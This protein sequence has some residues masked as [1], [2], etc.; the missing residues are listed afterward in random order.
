MTIRAI[1]ADNF[2]SPVVEWI[3]IYCLRKKEETLIQ[4]E[5][6]TYLAILVGLSADK[7]AF[8]EA[9]VSQN[10]GLNLDIDV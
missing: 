3:Q 6:R 8:F 4:D 5:R 10:W 2:V 7:N 1:E 9:W